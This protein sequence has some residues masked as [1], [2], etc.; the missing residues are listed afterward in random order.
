MRSS[1]LAS[2]LAAGAL[3]SGAAR[4]EPDPAAA[5]WYGALDLGVHLRQDQSTRSSLDE[6]GAGPARLRFHTNKNF[7]GF[8]RVGYRPRPRLRFEIEGGW[9]PAD[10]KSVVEYQQDKHPGGIL[11][12]CGDGPSPCADVPG[13]V[14]AWS[15]LANTYIDLWPRN[16]LHPYVGAGA[17]VGGVRL[18]A[19]GRLVGPATPGR[20]A[21]DDAG[22]GP[23]Y[24]AIGGLAYRIG[25]RWTADLS[26]RLFYAEPQHWDAATTGNIPL[27]RLSG[28][29]M[30]H[31]FTVGFR[32]TFA[33]P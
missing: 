18:R 29:Y 26:Y 6:L 9:R 32:Y 8:V 15:V 27:G 25:A 13:G 7:A 23:A 33:P 14:T 10:L 30:D 4:A 3:A 16:R 21:I 24:Q 31:A 17:G 22:V 12:V 5:A 11:G 19:E 20:I 1:L 28:P 2:V